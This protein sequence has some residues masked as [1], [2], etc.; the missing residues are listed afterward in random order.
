MR[1]LNGACPSTRVCD[2]EDPAICG[3]ENDITANFGWSRHT[4]ATSSSTTGATFG[5]YIRLRKKDSS[6]SIFT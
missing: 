6:D 4:G 5:K 3:Y 1:I 2:F